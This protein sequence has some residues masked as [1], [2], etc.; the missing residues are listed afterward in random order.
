M[1]Q[2]KFSEAQIM[3]IIKEAEGG[4]KVRDHARKH[5]VSEAT[6]YQWKSRYSGMEVSDLQRLKEL[7][8]ENSRLKRIVADQLLDI[9]ILKEVNAK[10]W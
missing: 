8:R 4:I 5:G 3:G 7:E 9:Q 1:K 10:K 6:I 2:S